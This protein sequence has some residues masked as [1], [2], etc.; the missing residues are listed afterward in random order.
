MSEPT[1][2]I[3]QRVPVSI[4]DEMRTS[5]LDYA[6]SVIIGRALPDVRDGL[7]PVHRRV[8]FSM[9]EQKI[10]A[11]SGYKK[12]A[13]VVGDVLGKYHP[14]GDLAVY[15]ALVRMGQPFSLRAMLID[16]QGNFGSVDGDSAAA[17]RYTEC[18]LS[19]LAGELLADIDKETVDFVPNYDEQESEPTVLPAKWPNLLVNGSEGIAV[20][21]ATKI[22]PHNLGETV[23]AAIA[24]IKNP[25]ITIDEL[26]AIMPGPDFPT[27]GLIYGRTGIEQAYRTGRGSIYVRG[28]THVEKALGK[29][30][31]EQIVLT[32]IPYQVNKARLHKRISEL[33]RDK[34]IEGIAEVRDESDREG[35]RLVVELKKDVFP[36][37]VLNQLFRMTDMQVTFGVI[38]LSVVHGR[39]AVLNLKQTLE[40]FVEHRR[41][42]V[43]RRCRY[44]LR[45]AEQQRELNLGYGMATTE[46]DL[47]VRTIRES[48]DGEVAKARLMALPLKGLEAYVRRAGRP[49]S[50]IAEAKAKGDY[51]L[52]ERQAKA[53]LDMRLSRLTGLERE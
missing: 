13:R 37:V 50:E 48:S 17:M 8:M 36:Q 43:T 10:N 29:T 40:Y 38:N 28:R 33:V 41:D 16:G 52:Y 51:F 35:I 12:C 49:E 39:P 25:D 23:S 44:E 31:R 9:H 20:G 47:V 45:I 5:Y 1:S 15:D 22:P 24:L 2:N 21:M 32:E 14:H 30:D 3:E 6:M 42:V 34:E 19:R 26:M 46:I 11:S 18:R 4:Q 27:G 7:K 53:I